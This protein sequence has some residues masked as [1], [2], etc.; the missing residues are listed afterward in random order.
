MDIEKNFAN[1]FSSSFYQKENLLIQFFLAKIKNIHQKFSRLF[2]VELFGSGFLRVFLWNICSSQII[3]G[4]WISVYLTF[5]HWHGWVDLKAFFETLSII[6]IFFF[7]DHKFCDTRK[8]A[9]WW[10][11]K[12]THYVFQP[13][14]FQVSNHSFIKHLNL[15]NQ[16]NW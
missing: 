6:R 10:F 16:F 11:I 5:L 4:W 7:D 2:W 15:F 13:P 12:S 14:H 8:T 9:I 3:L 1:E